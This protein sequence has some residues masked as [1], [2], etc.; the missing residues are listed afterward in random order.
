MRVPDNPRF[1][2]IITKN[3]PKNEFKMSFQEK[4]DLR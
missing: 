2:K 1:L 4:V 3:P